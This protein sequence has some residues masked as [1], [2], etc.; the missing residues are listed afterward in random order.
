MTGDIC[1]CVYISA[2]AL[3]ISVKNHDKS[4]AQENTNATNSFLEDLLKEVDICLGCDLKSCHSMYISS[5]SGLYMAIDGDSLDDP[6][7]GL[8][9][10]SFLRW[11]KCGSRVRGRSECAESISRPLSVSLY[12]GLYVCVY[13]CLCRSIVSPIITVVIRVTTAEVVT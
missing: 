9:C 13:R 6:F 10:H 1:E 8:F 3:G 11:H 4:H 7:G 5:G 12:F 2:D